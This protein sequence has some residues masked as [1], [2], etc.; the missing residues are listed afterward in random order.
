MSKDESTTPG[1]ASSVVPTSGEQ[2][3]L[4][5]KIPSKSSTDESQKPS[6]DVQQVPGE[7]SGVIPATSDQQGTVL[8]NSL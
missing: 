3:D 4:I 5:A 8:V 7:T 6:G 2:Q 1:E